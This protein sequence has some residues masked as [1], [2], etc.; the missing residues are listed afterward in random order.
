MTSPAGLAC[1]FDDNTVIQDMVGPQNRNLQRLEQRLDVR[2][3]LNGNM[4]AI[5][6]REEKAQRLSTRL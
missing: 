1:E 4:I 2:L 3:N 5:E 6:G